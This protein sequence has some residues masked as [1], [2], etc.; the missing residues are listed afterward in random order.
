MVFVSRFEKKKKNHTCQSP[1]HKQ[2]GANPRIASANAEF[3]GNLDQPASGTL[4]WK[5]LC[6]VDFAQHGISRLRD[7]CRGETGH[8]T[9]AKIYDRGHPVRCRR[10]VDLLVDQFRHF[11]VND[12]F[13]HRIRNSSP[14]VSA[15]T[16]YIPGLWVLLGLALTV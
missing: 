2:A 3:F 10:F 12:E 11:F 5:S 1:D 7:D 13:R 4:T 16:L 6:L 15:K 14:N 8:E 9:G